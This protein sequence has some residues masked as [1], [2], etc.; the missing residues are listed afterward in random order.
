MASTLFSVNT[1][2]AAKLANPEPAFTVA[3]LYQPISYFGGIA[4]A[5]APAAAAPPAAPAG[6][7]A[8]ASDLQI[9]ISSIPTAHDGQVITADYHNALRL[10]LVAIA[11]RMG[12]GPV[13][14]EI[15]VTVAPTLRP[16]ASGGAWANDYGTAVQGAATAGAMKGWIEADLPDGARIKKVIAYASGTVDTGG[17]L[18]IRLRR[19]K[20]TDSSTSPVLAEVVIPTGADLAKGVEADVTLPGTGAGVTAVE[21]FRV[22][23]NRQHKYLVTAEID[24]VTKVH[25]ATITAI[26]I[27]LGR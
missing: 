17:K 15:T 21:E 19:Q 7:A 13:S 1:N 16:A 5:P 14:D 12:L 27:I 4:T 8:S 10:A 2:Y 9:L 26:Q 3:T 22:V 18:T 11:N 25:N 23:D 20:I 24:D 6:P